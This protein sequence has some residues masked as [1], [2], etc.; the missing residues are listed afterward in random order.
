M[1][2]LQDHRQEDQGKPWVEQVVDLWTTKLKH[3]WDVAETYDYSDHTFQFDPGAGEYG[4]YGYQS[5]DGKEKEKEKMLLPPAPTEEEEKEPEP[6]VPH[7]PLS[8][9][10]ATLAL[11]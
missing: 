3:L 7:Q 11:S 8:K 5:E 2:D 9:E 4:L 1:V 6:D 10:I